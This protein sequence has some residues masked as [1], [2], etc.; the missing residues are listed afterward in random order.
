MLTLP[1]G[2]GWGGCTVSLV[3]ESEVEGFIDKIRNAYGPYKGLQGEELHEV[4]F[5]TKPSSGACGECF[6]NF[7]F[8]FDLYLLLHNS[9]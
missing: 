6:L 3:A 5:A 4:I 8:A 2:A 1:I 7:V 9:V